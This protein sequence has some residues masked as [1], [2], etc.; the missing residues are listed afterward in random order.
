MEGMSKKWI[1]EMKI[2]CLGACNIDPVPRE[3]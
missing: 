2:E 3:G 1:I